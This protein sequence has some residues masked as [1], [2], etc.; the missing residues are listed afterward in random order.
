MISEQSGILDYTISQDDLTIFYSLV[1]ENGESSINSFNILE[2]TISPAVE[3]SPGLCRSPKISPDGL[4]LA[5]EFISREPGEN[6]SIQIFNLEEKTFT[7]PETSTHHLDNPRWSPT[8]WLSYYNHTQQQYV[9]WNPETNQTLS[10]EN[11]T[12]R[13]GSWSA[14]GQYFVCT[15]IL[16]ISET[17]APRHLLLYDITEQT[18]VDL[19]EGNFLE[20]LNPS[21][22][23]QDLILAFSRK[24]LDPE[25]WSPGRQLWILDLEEQQASPLT[26]A[27]DFHH[28]SFAWHPD[29][30]QLAY[31]RYNQ[32]KLSDPP[33][34]WIINRDG[35]GN[36]RLIINGFSPSWIP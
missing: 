34:I 24:S 23:P 1:K 22:S 16:F 33:E 29:G 12:G 4:N 14:D 8:G 15:E 6:P 3:C 25:E 2:E 11:E 19:S 36:L 17:L 27:V 30:D 5:Y 18:V 7:S 31:V 20:D 28:T 35:S 9:F 10:L 26:S 13:D 21:F 32:A